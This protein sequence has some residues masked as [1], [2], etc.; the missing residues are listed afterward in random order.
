MEKSNLYLRQM[1]VGPMQNYVYLLGDPQTKEAAVIDPGWEP[2]TILKAAKE[3]GYKI[4]HIFATHTHFD[5][6]NALEEVLKKTDAKVCVHEQE[7]PFLPVPKDNL[8]KV[9]GGDIVKIGKIDVQFLHTPGHTPGSQ[10]FLVE[11][12]LI[13]GDTLFIHYCGRTDL[14]GGNNEQMYKSLHDCL[15]ALPPETVLYPGHNYAE[16]PTSTLSEEK[17]TNP[18]FGATSLKGFLR[19]HEKMI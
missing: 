9:K 14:P 19:L 3:D 4:S 2:E 15:G 13:S 17:K 18:Y 5:H 12:N 8:V 11:G 16:T 10:C 7:S 6:V 1:E